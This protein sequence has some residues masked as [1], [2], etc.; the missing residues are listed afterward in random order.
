[1]KNSITIGLVL[2][3][4]ITV[5]TTHAG[6]INGD[7]ET[8]DLTGWSGNATVHDGVADLSCSDL[9]HKYIEQSFDVKAGDLLFFEYVWGEGEI[10]G[11]KLASF[12]IGAYAY[13]NISGT[14]NTLRLEHK[15]V[16]CG[17]DYWNC[18]YSWPSSGW[19]SVGREFPNDGHVILEVSCETGHYSGGEGWGRSNFLVDNFC[20][21]SPS[22]LDFTITGYIHE[23]D[24]S[25]IEGVLV[26][27]SSLC[28]DSVTTD[29]NGYYELSVEPNWSGTVTP[30]LP[31]GTFNPSTLTY[32][33]VNSNLPDQNFTVEIF[34]QTPD[35]LTP[36][37]ESRLT[38]LTTTFEWTAFQDGG[39]GETQSGYQIRVIRDDET[40]QTV[41]D[42]GFIMDTSGH[43]HMYQ[44]PG[45]YSGFDSL[46][47]TLR[48]SEPLEYEKH[49]YWQVRYRDSDGDWSFWSGTDP[50]QDFFTQVQ[51]H[52]TIRLTDNEYDDEAP[53]INAGG[54]VAW[55]GFDSHDKEIFLYDGTNII[56]ITDNA[57]DDAGI[58]I[59]PKGFVVWI[60]S[61]GHDTEIFLY[62]G[63]GITQLT[64]ND[65][66]DGTY[67][68][69]TPR[70][71]PNG[72]VVWVESDG[73]DGE[74]FLY[75][76]NRTTQ[77]TDND[78][79]DSCPQINPSGYVVWAGGGEIFLYDGTDI[80]QITNDEYPGGEECLGLRMNAS[81]YVTWI[82]GP[83]IFLYYGK[84][85]TKLTD[86]WN[87]NYVS[88]LNNSGHIA[89][90]KREYDHYCIKLFDGI[91]TRTLGEGT[92]PKINDSGIV[93]WEGSM[94]DAWETQEIFLYDGLNI[95]QLTDNDYPDWG[96]QINS[97][98]QIVWKG[99][100]G[101][102]DYELFL[103]DGTRITRITDNE[104]DENVYQVN[105]SG[106]VV[107]Q[108]YDGHDYEIFLLKPI[109]VEIPGD[110]DGDGAVTYNDLKNIFVPAY[111]TH[112]GDPDFVSE[113]DMNQ[114]GSIDMVDY[115][116]WY[117]DF[118]NANQ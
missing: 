102:Q 101:N 50:L 100:V 32:A 4:L 11:Y 16:G 77:L 113:C 29:A 63:T 90:D 15:S 19:R 105:E 10:G 97:S 52:V 42:T 21:D 6:I 45:T 116:V 60:G 8:G 41:Y 92:S 31:T 24:G 12:S 67:W 79:R 34:P 109:E 93:V 47:D 62:D 86:D 80:T 89:W 96:P 35:P 1:M 37:I 23:P 117:E 66:D 111:G 57:Y 82:S 81:G 13:Y 59:N 110:F 40:D 88:R 68:L 51:T 20:I 91:S 76:G 2:F 56:Q 49:Y 65:Y 55:V 84:S 74:I 48:V 54:H 95:I 103:Y 87:E 64:D 38:T 115:A 26:A 112:T 58:Q 98:G 25:P 43:A 118:M 69:E 94:G 14:G 9:N 72:H 99:R 7:F 75:D 33:D 17:W 3:G 104:Y 22:T 83:N 53:Q 73:F 71:N 18:G 61:D 28:V 70:I 5:C 106:Y 27:T 78:Y 107:W 108:E 114:D 39:D 46:A 30:T 36:S 44:P 85:R